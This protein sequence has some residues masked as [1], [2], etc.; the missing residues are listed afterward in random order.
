MATRLPSSPPC[1]RPLAA[2]SSS[3]AAFSTGAA[4]THAR[5][6]HGLLHFSSDSS[7]QHEPRAPPS[8]VAPIHLSRRGRGSRG[9][10]RL[11]LRHIHLVPLAG[12]GGLR[13]RSS[14]PGRSWLRAMLCF[15]CFWMFFRHVASLYFKCFSCFRCIFQL[16]HTDVANVDR[17]FSYVAIVVHVCCKSLSPIFH[18]FFLYTYIASV[19]DT[20]L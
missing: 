4:A 14:P 11:R 1:L 16:F 9:G 8:G 12:K 7:H 13:H 3:L 10:L 5:S 15:K 19:S 6:R 20:C 2:F 18:L 17:D